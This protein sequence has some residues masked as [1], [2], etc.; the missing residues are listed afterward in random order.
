[1]KG[2]VGVL[3]CVQYHRA[4]AKHIK[5]EVNADAVIY[6]LTYKRPQFLLFI[7]DVSAVVYIK[8]QEEN[9]TEENDV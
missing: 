8:I 5:E 2:M 4:N 6:K 9:Y 7:E 3:F 1:M